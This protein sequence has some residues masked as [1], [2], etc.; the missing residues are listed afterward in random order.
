MQLHA[1]LVSCVKESPC[2][3]ELREAMTDLLVGVLPGLPL[4]L[5]Q[6]RTWAAACCVTTLQLCSLQED[7]G[8]SA[9]IS[10]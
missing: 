4:M 1:I 9:L 2:S 8:K 10:C 3:A 6:Q 5:P 7:R